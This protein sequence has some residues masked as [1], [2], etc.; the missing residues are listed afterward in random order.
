MTN[1]ETI[2][3]KKEEARPYSKASYSCAYTVIEQFHEFMGMHFYL[4][5]HLKMGKKENFFRRM[6]FHESIEMVEN[7]YC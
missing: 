3:K 2:Q 6:R 1:I 4:N 7:L 5:G